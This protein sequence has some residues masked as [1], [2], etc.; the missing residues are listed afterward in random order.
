M[1]RAAVLF[2]G[3]AAAGAAAHAQDSESP[4]RVALGFGVDTTRSPEREIFELYRH[5][6]AHRQDTIRPHPD[7][8]ATRLVS[9]VKLIMPPAPVT[10]SS[11][12]A[13][14]ASPPVRQV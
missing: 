13:L 6:L 8:S 4:I 14:L 12:H 11:T 7:W 10:L 2:L 5:Y 9:V 3:M 1:K